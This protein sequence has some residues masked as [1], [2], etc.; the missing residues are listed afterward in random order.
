MKCIVLLRVTR[1]QECYQDYASDP[2]YIAFHSNKTSSK[3]CHNHL[4][5][6]LDRS[7]RYH[8]IRWLAISSF[9][10]KVRTYHVVS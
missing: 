10:R 6:I 4:G 7:E 8:P 2:Q 1:Y 5:N 3:L 9:R